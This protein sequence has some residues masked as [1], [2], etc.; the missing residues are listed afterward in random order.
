MIETVQFQCKVVMIFGVLQSSC[1]R[2]QSVQLIFLNVAF[3]EP[4][5]QHYKNALAWGGVHL[6]SKML[7]NTETLTQQNPENCLGSF[8]EICRNIVSS[9][10]ALIFLK[11]AAR[12]SITSSDPGRLWAV[13]SLDAS[14]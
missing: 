3:F 7:T 12:K 5:V 9:L 2:F 6:F 14:K 11:K 4:K 13:L 1:Q 8:V 10:K